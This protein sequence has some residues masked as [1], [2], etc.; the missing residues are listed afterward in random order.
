M[1]SNREKSG[2]KPW[3]RRLLLLSL[4]GCCVI[5]PACTCGPP[6]SE[7][8]IPI[9]AASNDRTAERWPSPGPP[10]QSP[11]DDGNPCTYDIWDGPYC[12]HVLLQEGTACDDGD[13]CNG[14]GRC[15]ADGVCHQ[16]GALATDD[17]NDCTADACDPI[18]GVQHVAKTGQACT[19]GCGAQSV[20]DSA[21]AC[22]APPLDDGNPCTA[23]LCHPL[24]GVVHENEPKGTLC[25]DGNVCN[26]LARC[27]GF[28]ACA[29]GPVPP[30]GTSCSDGQVCNGAE[31]CADERCWPGDAPAAG[32]ACDD[33]N[34]CTA[35][36]ACDGTSSCAGVAVSAG[37]ACDDGNACTGGDTCDGGGSCGGSALGGVPC[38]D[39]DACNG[40]ETC[41]AGACGVDPAPAVDDGDPATLD[42]CDPVTGI[43]RHADCQSLDLTVPTTVGDMVVC[44][45]SGP[46]AVQTGMTEAIDPIRAGAIRGK[47]LSASHDPLSGVTVTLRR[48]T[49][50]IGPN[51]LPADPQLVPAGYGSTLTRSDGA[52]DLAVNGGGSYVLEYSRP[53]YLPAQREITP[54]AGRFV[55]APDVVLKALDPAVTAV[56]IGPATTDVQVARSSVV[57]DFRGTRQ[58]TVLFQ[59]GTTATLEM[60]DGTTTALPA[61][62]IHVRATEYT[63]GPEGPAAMP[64]SLPPST[65]Y[66]Y[67]VELTVDE[68]LAAGA[69]SVLFNPPVV[70]YLENF[71][72][73]PPAENIPSGSY[74]ADAGL[75]EVAPNGRVIEILGATNGA[76]DLNIDGDLAADP[77]AEL[78]AIGIALGERE[79]LAELYAPGQTLWRIPVAHF[80]AWDW[81]MGFG[82]GEGAAFPDAS[83]LADNPRDDAC[84]QQGSIIGCENRSLGEVFGVIGTPFSLHYQSDRAPGY[85]LP[86]HVPATGSTLPLNLLRVFVELDVAGQHFSV[87]KPPLPDTDVDF[88]WD[89]KNGFGAAVQGPQVAEVSVGYEFPGV[90]AGAGEF[91]ASGGSGGSPCAVCFASNASGGPGSAFVN[92]FHITASKDLTVTLW[93]K[94]RL[95]LHH[96]NAVHLGLGGLTLDVHHV[97]DPS[98][99]VLYLGNGDKH[100]G[101]SLITV[102]TFA[103]GGNSVASNIPAKTASLPAARRLARGPDGSFYVAAATS[104][105]AAARIV[106]VDGEEVLT[107]VWTGPAGSQVRGIAVGPEGSLYFSEVSAHQVYRIPP[108]SS[109]PLPFAGSGANGSSGDG[110]L[111]TSAALSS[112]QGLAVA[113]DGSVYIADTGNSRI[114]RVDVEGN[115]WKVAGNGTCNSWKTSAQC[116][117][118]GLATSAALN[119]PQDVAVG[120]GGI[121]YIADTG[122]NRVRAVTPDGVIHR[123]AGLAQ[124]AANVSGGPLSGVPAKAA[125][126]VSPQ[127]VAVA[128]DGGLYVADTG[129]GVVRRIEPPLITPADETSDTNGDIFTVAGNGGLGVYAGEGGL[130]TAATLPAATG[131]F[132]ASDSTLYIADPYAARVLRVRPA[133]PGMSLAN[134]SVVSEDGAEVY[135]FDQARRHEKT[136]DS[137]T[138]TTLFAFEY[139]AAH[140]LSKV[141][142][143]E[144]HE[145]LISR[146]PQAGTVSLVGPYGHTTTVTLGADGYAQ[147]I[148]GPDGEAVHL[149]YQ[150]VGSGLLTWLS[151]PNDHETTFTYDTMGR[152]E[153]DNAPGGGSKTLST[154]LD[155]PEHRTVSVVTA[156]GRTTS[157]EVDSTDP[158][159]T[160]RKATG[161]D[162]LVSVTEIAKPGAPAGAALLPGQVKTTLPDGSTILLEDAPDPRLGFQ[163]PFAKKITTVTGGITQ[164][165]TRSRT[166]TYAPNDL[167]DVSSLVDQTT[168]NSAAT[169]TT[170]YQK[171]ANG[172]ATWTRTSP[173]NRHGTITADA[174]GRPVELSAPGLAP[175]TLQYYP[176]G[177]HQGRVW[178][179]SQASGGETRTTEIL[180]D[181]AGNVEHVI[182]PLQ[183]TTTYAHDP[184]GRVTSATTPDNHVWSFL[185][186]AAG[187]VTGVV[188]PGPGGDHHFAYNSR[189]LM[190]QWAPADLGPGD[191]ATYYAYST[192]AE[193]VLVTQAD[194]TEIEL[195][196]DPVS[197]RLTAVT[198]PTGA[199]SFTYFPNASAAPGKLES[200][201][202][203]DG[204]AQSFAYL[205]ALVTDV[206]WTGPVPGA[207][208]YTYDDQFRTKSEA[209]GNTAPVV[210]SWNLDG[211]LVQSGDLQ[212]TYDPTTGMF[213]GMTLG[214]VQDG[215]VWSGFG[216]A[217]SYTAAISSPL[218][219]LLTRTFE[220]DA[221]GRLLVVTETLGGGSLIETSYAYDLAGRLTDVWQDGALIEHYSHDTHGN[222]TST[223]L[224]GQPAIAATFDVQDRILTFGA[225]TY[226]HAL[227]G[228][229]LSKTTPAGPTTSTYDTLGR[230]E[231][232]TLPDGTF[233]EY[234][235]DAAGRRVAKK[236]GGAFEQR[237]L[238]GDALGPVAL[239]DAAG[240]VLDRYVYATS[241]SVPDYVIR[242]AG[243]QAGTYR[244]IKDER[245]SVRLVVN[246]LTG[247]IAQQLTYD[248]QGRVLTDTNPGF[249]PFGF[250]GGLWEADTGLVRFGLRDYD[251]ETGRWTT[252]DPIG[253]GGGDTNLYA[254]A[255]G[256]PVNGTD[257]TGLFVEGN[258]AMDSALNGGLLSWLGF[259]Q[260]ARGAFNHNEGLLK[261]SNDATFNEGL[262]QMRQG[263]C[264]MVS[265]GITVATTTGPV[266]VGMV[267]A[268]PGLAKLG[269]NSFR[270]FKGFF[271]GAGRGKQWHHIVEQT[272]RNLVRFGKQRIHNRENMVAVEK[273]VHQ[274][275]S[276][277]YSSKDPIAQGMTVREWLSS[278]SW[279]AQYNFGISIL[280]DFGVIP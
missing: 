45:Y 31:T 69:R 249:T 271:G 151:D 205:G 137:M 245:G 163:A 114:R 98:G 225:T 132:V 72:D 37:A 277:I 116:G 58:A 99:A 23:D 149:G 19:G 186:D 80:T 272:P 75:W 40:V 109:T 78:A 185:H 268:L 32:T 203:A 193:P 18:A 92:N 83:A 135:I 240:A 195:V 278:Q 259:E 154:P 43:V 199:T 115:I 167:T 188:P 86:I 102:A 243:P 207:L 2:R 122:S 267:G 198:T 120:P 121:I 11:C 234:L 241:P 126:L 157:Y 174:N 152:L 204:V 159:V 279:E 55:T 133:L 237:F 209:A 44:L 17:G 219:P 124:G 181:A 258:S 53:G 87:E 77:P 158:G 89:G 232:V 228:E 179:V 177:P 136:I 216:E 221:L 34:P 73:L 117:D 139:D 29:A 145:T 266:A 48:R 56:E 84:K 175:V 220:R 111:A 129:Q 206:A 246:V 105:S 202:S 273:S 112:P 146:D 148:Q 213:Q 182:S 211:Q 8:T 257:P 5:A 95:T 104:G 227:T 230:L 261:L 123:V 91:G 253:L 33:A 256:D 189:D 140:L 61:G 165:I 7:G 108:G 262:A 110:G 16:G 125:Q 161:P 35:V 168:I 66:T 65:A 190:S 81:N 46:G 76:A 22:G 269:F 226:T 210:R 52:F 47:V 88:V 265:G 184:N 62:D 113:P 144:G 39:G 119:Q 106:K 242:V 71:L 187:N 68:A 173:L 57:S 107:T 4:V 79:R 164:T 275:V 10:G 13:V 153:S 194:G 276:G 141:T 201:T 208:H 21:G 100:T 64:A 215:V 60:P 15:D 263:I 25:D 217:D 94:H 229:R 212:L 118:G 49:A 59:P 42:T 260:F 224:A 12:D 280:E 103:G 28:G 197:G 183:Q 264:Q 50:P 235:Y 85:K 244:L 200:V 156:Q 54:E 30:A 130:A 1:A 134:T 214:V 155:E 128:P 96:L 251:P 254:Y 142:D 250:G 82:P 239:V 236:V 172:T 138:G 180:Y 90:Y 38:G 162:G 101:D 255:G 191:E 238:Y 51:N 63:V 147:S 196:F 150:S 252:Q 20:C 97:Y 27:D 24:A 9:V 274:A 169:W 247:A 233:I 143:A 222:R 171:Q 176:W 36:D 170:T 270:S 6:G 192:D 131:L 26:G 3:T 41:V 127:G 223:E 248:S 70:A 231:S 218:T 160:V 93:Q 166:A 178:K 14:S 67:A 74:R